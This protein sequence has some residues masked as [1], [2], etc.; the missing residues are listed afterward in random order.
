MQT[1]PVQ[2]KS[3]AW[4]DFIQKNVPH[5]GQCSAYDTN[6]D[7]MTLKWHMYNA[8]SPEC[9]QAVKNLSEIFIQT[10]TRQEVEFAHKKPKKVSTDM[11]L[12][13]VAHLF[14]NGINNVDWDAV[15][16]GVRAE[17]EDFFRAK[18]FAQWANPDEIVIFVVA[19]NNG[20]EQLGAIQ[21]CASPDFAYGN[22]KVGLAGILTDFRLRGI[23]RVLMGSIFKIL[24]T[25][26]RIFLHNRPTN[27]HT[28][29]LYLDWGF[30]Q[31]TGTM[32]DWLDFEY[33]A[34]NNKTL[35]RMHHGF[36]DSLV[37]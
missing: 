25:T 24:P 22:V 33:V 30:D 28:I 4:L 3:S 19:Q 26:T 11:F 10:Y 8:A 32:E 35:Q 2:K 16:K 12:K 9:T 31:I 7:R 34:S 23:Q 14:A 20:G 15:E 36:G 29:C 21:F 5:S 13:G 6:Y 1:N 18:D 17:M 37:L 27:A